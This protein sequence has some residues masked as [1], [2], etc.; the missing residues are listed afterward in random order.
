LEESS[1]VQGADGG[2]DGLGGDSFAVGE[3]RRR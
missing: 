1:L 2:A 3:L